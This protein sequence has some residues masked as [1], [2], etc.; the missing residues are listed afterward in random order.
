MKVN[1]VTEGNWIKKFWSDKIVEYNK[2]E[3]EQ[4]ISLEPKNDVD[5]NFYVCY[6]TFLPFNKTNALDVGYVTHIHENSPE[7]HSIDI[8]H[9]F[10]KFRQLDAWIHQSKRSLKQFLDMGYPKDKNFNLTSPV[11]VHKFKPT[12][13]IGIFQN[14]E[15]VG[16]GLHFMEDFVDSG[17]NLE[18]FKFIFCGRGWESVISRLQEKNIRYETYNYTPEEYHNVEH[19]VLYEKI[20]YLLVPSLWEGGPVAP[21]EAMSCGIPIISSDVGLIPE[22]NIEYMFSAG[23][24]TSLMAI[25]KD[26]ENQYLKRRNKVI[27]LTYENFNE[28]LY[29]IF[30]G[31][32][33]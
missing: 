1:I 23:T 6:N 28:K 9:D 7:S 32:L 5:V 21:L 3:M 30:K 8:G 26:I 13:S 10:N 24:L 14:G 17:I 33:G 22:F 2:T 15:V 31:L 19:R 11:E 25:F 29:E 4:T 18:N 16:K 12:I 27:N 20:D